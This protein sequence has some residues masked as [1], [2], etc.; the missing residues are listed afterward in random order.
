MR[1]K[2]KVLLGNQ[3]GDFGIKQIAVTVAVIVIIGFI[4]NQVQ[5]FMPDW[6]REIW[7]M[8]MDQIK[9]LIS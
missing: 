2:I 3:R 8:F 4:V 1:G 7:N 5:A 9:G 6:V